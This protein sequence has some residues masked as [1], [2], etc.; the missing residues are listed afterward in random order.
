MGVTPRLTW[1][2]RDLSTSPYPDVRELR[3]SSP[4][5]ELAVAFIHDLRDRGRSEKTIP[6][7]AAHVADLIIFLERDGEQAR[8]RDLDVP[9]VLAFVGHVR[10]RP[11]RYGTGPLSSST[12]N[13]RLVAVRGLLRFG[14]LLDLPVP[15]AERVQLAAK[16]YP[17]PDAR[18]LGDDELR[19]LLAAPR[20]RTQRA[21]RARALMEFL[22]AT[23]CRISEA[24]ALNRAQLE[25]DPASPTPDDG[26][27][28]ADEVTVFGKGSRYRRVYL[29]TRA[30]DWMQRYLATRT[31]CLPALF[32]VGRRNPRRLT[33][34]SAQQA[35]RVAA[36]DAGI[37]RPISP[38]WLRHA[39]VTLWARFDLDAAR[40]LAG[41][42][43][44]FRR[45]RSRHG[46][47]HPHHAEP[48]G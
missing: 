41:D 10:R 20:G 11:R 47:G 8:I 18:H 39:A 1:G 2:W 30:R 37:D 5:R 25:L 4:L 42:A 36:R 26:L 33:I 17:T 45:G 27:R 29:T 31:D 6:R 44:A 38:H 23:G 13:L 43:D 12:T 3:P 7:Y 28:I 46:L 15:S 48:W 16:R 14:A 9:T 19:R 35:V 40:R 34:W 32:V 24:L 21:I 22:Y